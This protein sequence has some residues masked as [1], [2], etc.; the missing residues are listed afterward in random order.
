MS[1]IDFTG[2]PSTIDSEAQLE[3][4]MST[5]P[6]PLVEFLGGLDGDLMV[7]GVGGKMGTELA[8][9]AQR[10]LQQAGS[11]RSVIGVSR[12][13][14]PGKRERLEAGGVRTIAADLMDREALSG[15]PDAPNIIFMAGRK[16][17]TS[18]AAELTWAMNTLMPATVAERFPRS[19]IV[20]FSTG[21]VYP[22]V[23]VTRGGAR[24][25]DDPAPVGEYAITTLGRE[26]VFQ[27]YSSLNGTPVCLMR[28][29]YA[30]DLRYGVLYDIGSRVRAG[31]PVDLTM[32]NANVIWQGD[33]V[34]HALYALSAC[35]SPARIL[36]V[37]G[38]EIMSIRW[39]AETFAGLMGTEARFTGEEQGRALIGNAAEALG[40]F[41]YPRVP[42]RRMIEW[43]AHWIEIGGP[44][45]DKPTHFETSDG[46]Y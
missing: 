16:F 46:S 43:T 18:G 33:A 20:A 15:L 13:S 19:R 5:P 14:A 29:N 42:L 31:E 37:T 17:G 35:A 30:I 23:P 2:L 26:R 3:E 4:V 44:T 32:G 40:R 28:L 38:P 9:M 22:L 34:A 45:L 27:Y 39:A 24:E 6:A 12:F 1:P 11:S 36:N 41:G 21:N 8:L 10:A 7:L 25:T